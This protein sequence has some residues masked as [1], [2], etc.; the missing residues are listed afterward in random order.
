LLFLFIA[1]IGGHYVNG[2]RI[3][4]QKLLGADKETI[5]PFSRITVNLNQV[6]SGSAIGGASMLAKFYKTASICHQM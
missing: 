6:K 1:A 3:V 2:S 4:G 5:Y